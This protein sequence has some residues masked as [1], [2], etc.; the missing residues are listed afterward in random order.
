VRYFAQHQHIWLWLV[1]L[2]LLHVPEN[3]NAADDPDPEVDR[4]WIEGTLHRFFGNKALT[5][6]NLDGEGLELV[7]PYV[8]HE[9]KTIEVVIVR[10]VKSFEDGW[11]NDRTSA[12]RMLNSFSRRFQ[13]YTREIIIRQYLLFEA[14]DSL[15]P[16]ELADTERMLRDLSYINDVRIHVVPIDGEPDKVGIVVE[17]NDRWPLGITATVI[18]ADKWRARLYSNNVA[19]LGISF[20]NEVLYNK[21]SEKDWGYRGVLAKRNIAGSF[22]DADVDYENSYRKNSLLLALNRYLV[23]PDVKFIG[24][25]QWQDFEEFDNDESDRAYYETDVWMGKGI[26]LYDRMSVGGGARPMLVPAVRILDRDHYKRPQVLPDSNRS[27]HDFTQYMTSLTWQRLDSYKTSF[28]FGEGEVEDLPTGQAM[29]ISAVLEDREFE[30]RPGLF[31]DSALVSMRNRGDVAALT[32]SLGGFFHEEQVS[33]GALNIKTSYF[34]QLLGS[35]DIRHRVY[36]VLGYTLGIGRHSTDRIYLDNSSGVYNLESGVV[37]GNQRLVFRSFYR[38]FTSWALW[39]F[40]MSFFTFADVGVIGEDD[41]PFFKEKYYLS[42]GLGVRLRNPSLV[43][44]TVQLRMS[45]ITNVDDPGLLFGVKVGNV[46][47]PQV[48]FPG[49]RPSTLGYN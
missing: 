1:F 38:M 32:F 17:T 12:E 40:R 31:F 26:K 29:K 2:I 15:V 13:D 49:T 9:G 27:V 42:T 20:S 48:V 34:T 14:G 5:G 25:V 37:A 43:F 21:E 6:E 46:S 30:T 44:P 23:H 16:F 47:T 10:Q 33:E 39:G 36:F 7:G 35:G 8:Q 28:L 45:L 11:D 24:G 3:L 22:W 18:T 41:S 4:N 19:G